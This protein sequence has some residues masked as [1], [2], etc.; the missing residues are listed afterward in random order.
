MA[1]V[2]EFVDVRPNLRLPGFIV[3][4]R[5]AA[6]GAA[7]MQADHDRAP[8]DRNGSGQFDED[9]AYFLNFFILAQQ[10][11]VAQ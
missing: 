1:G 6:G 3:S 7:C 5:F 4:G 8:I 10:V 2:L 11:F 9:A